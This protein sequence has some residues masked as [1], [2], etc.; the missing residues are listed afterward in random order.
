MFRD[1]DNTLREESLKFFRNLKLKPGFKN[2]Y[3]KKEE[4]FQLASTVKL[5]IL[6]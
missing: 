1:F 4:H 3:N 6:K 2:V 5:Q